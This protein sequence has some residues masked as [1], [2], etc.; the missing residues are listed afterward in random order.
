MLEA[1][2]R[3]GHQLA[4][5]ASAEFKRLRKCLVDAQLA[6]P[7]EIEAGLQEVA[8]LLR[9]ENLGQKLRRE[10]GTTDPR[11]LSRVA[12]DDDVFEA[13]TPLGLL[14]HISP[15]NSFATGPLSVLEGLLTGNMNVLKTGTKESLF[16]QLFLEALTKADPGATLRE[17]IIVA[18]IPSR[19]TSLLSE[20]FAASDGI[21]VWG[22]EETVENIRKLAPPHVRLVE[23]GHRISLIY[24]SA[25]SAPIDEV[26]ER[27][28]EECCVLDQ[29][30]CASPQCIYV[31]TQ[32]GK[33]LRDFADRLAVAMQRVSPRF[34]ALAAD[35]REAAEITVV[36]ECHR[37]ETSHGQAKLIEGPKKDWRIFVD[38]RDALVASPLFRSVW[39]K[40]LPREKIVSVLRPMRRYL[41][42]AGLA[43]GLNDLAEL[44]RLSPFRRS[45]PPCRKV[46]EMQPSYAE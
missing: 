37:L 15:Q 8:A 39:V 3:L 36:T 30:S 11:L 28:A 25:T 18:R 22:G 23:W 27:T 32:S 1:A 33:E 2:D 38:E 4:N 43:C 45:D 46:G 24:L 31:E 13:W 26:I 29:Q 10:L 12:Y 42:T 35:D 5:S 7:S 20:I 41:Q 40:P 14:V 9:R 21:A 6:S 16:P 44:S 17:R 19:Q 34:P